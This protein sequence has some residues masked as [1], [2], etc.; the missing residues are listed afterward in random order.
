MKKNLRFAIIAMSILGLG[1]LTSCQ[2]SEVENIEQVAFQH[3]YESGFVKTFGNVAPTR[4]GISLPMPV[5]SG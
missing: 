1:S 5:I 3:G 2:D 4:R